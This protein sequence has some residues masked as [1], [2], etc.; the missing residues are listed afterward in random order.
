MPK[1]RA[2]GIFDRILSPTRGDLAPDLARYILSL[3]FSEED[4]TRYEELSVRA[5]RGQLSKSEAA[6]LD[7]LL[8]A[9]SFLIVLQSKARTSLARKK[10][11]A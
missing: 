10:P 8:S 2:S 4:K 1:T 9:N 11:A 6:D 5:Q 3:D 7:E